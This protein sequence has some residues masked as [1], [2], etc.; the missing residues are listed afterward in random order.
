MKNIIIS[1]E[2]RTKLKKVLAVFNLPD[3]SNEKVFYNM[4]FCLCTP[5]TTF[6]KNK[7]V[8]ERLIE[9]KLYT[10]RISHEKLSEMIREVRFRNNK[11]R[12]L[13]EA[14]ERF[15]EILNIVNNK[16]LTIIEKRRWLVK[17]INGFG[18]KTASHFLR[19][20]GHTDLAIIDTHIVKFM[21]KESYPQTQK[22]Y[23]KIEMYFK[24]V[25]TQLKVTPVELDAYVWK[26][27]SGT[28]WEEFN[29]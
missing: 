2:D 25:A 22:E 29:W 9:N 24:K 3:K 8:I 21:N 14:K 15:D 10:S 16:S 11:A 12:W 20:L 13:L 4:C 26:T 6:K 7:I 17:N 18:M 5:Q 23:E 19:N 27:Y 1:S 28:S